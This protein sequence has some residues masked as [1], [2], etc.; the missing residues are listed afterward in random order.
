MNTSSPATP[1]PSSRRGQQL[2]RLLAPYALVAGILILFAV[3]VVLQLS[4]HGQAARLL[5]SGCA[6]AMAAY[7]A[8]GMVRDLL[9]GNW[10]VDVLAVIAIVSTVAVGEYLASMVIVVML[11]GG[12]AL[13]EYAAGRAG[14]ELQSLLERAPQVAHRL[15]P[16][17]GGLDDVP[18]GEI[19]PGDR[20]LVR[21]AEV[22]PVDGTLDSDEAAIDES[23]LTGESIPVTRVAGD[24]LL[25]GSVNGGAAIEMIATRPAAESQYQRIVA[26]VSEAQERTA[27]L[28]RLADRYAVRSRWYRC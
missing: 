2:A 6:L 26:L 4:G 1:D 19:L 27:P 18:A 20:L 24:N 11:T 7:T 5:G 14:R 15:H 16:R 17:T 12:E 13:E 22:L 3:V 9:R 28:V 8:V 23:S 10:G 21:P 25:S